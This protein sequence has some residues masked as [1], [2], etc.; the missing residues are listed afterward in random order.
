VLAVGSQTLQ[1]N[2]TPSNLSA[3]T[4]ATVS[5]TLRVNPASL[6]ITANKA[7]REY[8]IANPAFTGTIFGA[9]NHDVLT[10]S[11]STSATQLSSPGTYTI[12][13]SVA[14]TH[15]SSYNVTAIPGVLTINKAATSIEMSA[16]AT[17]VS[18]GTPVTF[19][20]T[21][22]S[23]SKEI[24]IGTVTLYS[25]ASVVATAR[26]QNGSANFTSQLSTGTD[27]VTAVY[28]G[29]PNFDGSTSSAV[30][31]SVSDFE[32]TPSSGSRTVVPGGT[33]LYT[34]AVFGSGGAFINAIKFS[35]S[36][37]PAGATA[38]FDPPTVTPNRGSPSTT[39][40]IQVPPAGTTARTTWVPGAGRILS[41]AVLLPLFGLWHARR[42]LHRSLPA[43]TLSL[44]LGLALT[45][46]GCGSSGFFD[47]PPQTYSITITGT[48]GDISHS[49]IV[50]LTVE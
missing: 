20:A 15:L 50:T 48:S 31:I 30:T 9:V 47:Q 43:W 22:G 26:L 13:P 29:D 17:S 35:A 36:G 12:V 11:F 39:L 32:F 18:G 19:H 2:F 40:A 8:G 6:T 23:T 34:F 37:L 28:S 10:E 38:T 25:N 1:A 41:L 45:I 4:K 5:T 44:F 14:G 42:R 7:T 21:V 3:Y 16:V 49:Q 24:P 27:S 33:A 46:S